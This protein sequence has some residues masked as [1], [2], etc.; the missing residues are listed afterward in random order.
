MRPL[1]SIGVFS[2]LRNPLNFLLKGSYLGA[3]SGNAGCVAAWWPQGDIV[4]FNTMPLQHRMVAGVGRDER[5]G[6]R[7]H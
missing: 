7:K 1:E 2:I 5:W 6:G 3:A 4:T